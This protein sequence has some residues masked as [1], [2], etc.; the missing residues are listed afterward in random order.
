[1]RDY[2]LN[3]IVLGFFAAAQLDDFA[4]YMRTSEG[5]AVLALHMLMSSVQEVADL[6]AA[7]GSAAGLRPLTPQPDSPPH[8]QIVPNWK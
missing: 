8:M 3:A 7:L 4:D 6:P 5:R 2:L 1:M